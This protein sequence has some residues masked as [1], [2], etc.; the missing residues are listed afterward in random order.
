ML[1][2]TLART[3][4]AAALLGGALIGTPLLAPALGAQITPKSGGSMTIAFKDD[5]ATLDPA[6]GYDWQNWP[7]IESIFNGL[8]TFEPGTTKLKMS[9]ADSYTV[10]PDGLTYT[11]KLHPGVKFSNGRL[12]TADDVVYS[13]NR[14]CNPKT[15]SPGASFFSAI[16]GF[17]DFQKGKADHLAGMSAPDPSTVVIK[18][19]RP[20]APFPYVLTLNFAFVVPKE[21]VQKAGADWAKHPVG[22]GPFILKEWTLGQKLVLVRNPDYWEKGLPYLDSYTVEVGQEPLTALLRLQHGEIDALGDGIPPAKFIEVMKDP[23]LKASVV[24]GPRIET[25]YLTMKTN[26]KPFDDVRV[27]QAVNY[28]INKARIIKIVNG[29]A[30]AA[31]QVLPPSMPGYDP[32]YKG[33]GFNPKKAKELLKEAGLAGGFQTVLFATNTDPN[34]RIAQAIQQDL[35]AVGIKADLKT[36]A[37][38]NVIAAGGSPD[39]A[40]MV[41][42]GGM[43][44]SDDFPDPSDFYTPILSCGSA[45][46]GGWNW[47]WYC[48]KDLD[49]A[50]DKAN[51][52]TDPAKTEQR[53]DAWRAIY[54][55]VMGD[56]PWVPIMNEKLYV[57]K[58]A[59]LH[60]AFPGVLADPQYPPINY[61]YAWVSDG[62]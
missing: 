8:I 21:E 14:T 18:L 46:Q 26:Q 49:A 5:I 61:P 1:K 38:E 48:R 17:D 10:S 43:A 7:V 45:T 34:P 60:G 36:L 13:F 58:S 23:K 40:P 50:A 57:M 20:Y 35:A 9:L 4:G 55:T 30:V 52:I 47:A 59:R 41:F 39:Q 2:S 37:Q 53:M 54:R 42:S 19:T 22:T 28:A 11:F 62:K 27:R 44:W 25:T 12:M 33:Y 16:D 24:E 31:D 51:A 15:Q 56:A 32:A 6:I 3:V 29:R